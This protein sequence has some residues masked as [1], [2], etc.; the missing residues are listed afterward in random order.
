MHSIPDDD[1]GCEA[2]YRALSADHA[3]LHQDHQATLRKL[4]DAESDKAALHRLLVDPVALHR[5][6]D[7]FPPESAALGDENV[8]VRRSSI[9]GAGRGAFARRSF[10]A[11]EMVGQFTCK[12]LPETEVIDSLRS[13]GMNETHS[14]DASMFPLRN[15]M[16]YVNSVASAETCGRQNVKVEKRN[17]SVFYFATEAI[18]EGDE[19][20]ISYGR[21]YFKLASPPIASFE[22]GM[23]QLN[24]ASAQGDLTAVHRLLTNSSDVDQVST[25]STDDDGWTP[26]FEAAAAGHAA[27]V[28]YLIEQAA[29]INRADVSRSRTALSLA[30]QQGHVDV[31]R[32]FLEFE[33]TDTNLAD[34]NGMTPLMMASGNGHA[35]AAM[36][37][38]ENDEVIVSI[39][40]VTEEGATALFLASHNGHETVVRAL[41]AVPQ[42]D[43][44]K[45]TNEGASPLLIGSQNGHADVV[46][47]LVGSPNLV[48][49]NQASDDGATALTIAI[50]ERHASVVRV[51]LESG[52]DAN[53]ATKEMGATPLLLACQNGH[54]GL[55]S[56]LLASGKV[57]TSKAA[58]NGATAL[59][60]ASTQ[61]YSSVV[62]QLLAA[63]ADASNTAN[64]GYNLLELAHAQGHSLVA[65]ALLER[66]EIASERNTRATKSARKELQ[67][68]AP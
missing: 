42:V 5:S 12:V 18:R 6:N 9:E 55:V 3:A 48:A 22:C 67:A 34:K 7:D 23:L 14:C 15:P 16:L 17:G 30:C 36:A 68:T 63:G 10:E 65:E 20:L 41:L 33:S 37:L 25:V 52:A 57:D 28:R 44:N 59:L 61:G 47:A 1:E 13:W 56:L 21:E 49:I 8:A 35:N 24:I 19:I 26:L 11:G 31:V 40:R 58:H 4:R 60:L 32:I 54:S 39:N 29:D 53:Q 43:A 51:L 2:K 64:S 62:R 46:R 50:Q 27:V 66:S 38:L 45:A